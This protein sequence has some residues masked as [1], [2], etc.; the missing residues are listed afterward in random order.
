MCY[1]MMFQGGVGHFASAASDS[2]SQMS[3]IE[4]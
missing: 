3:Q 2:Y 4:V 1:L